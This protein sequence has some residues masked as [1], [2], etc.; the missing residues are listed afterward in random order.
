M[1]NASAHR[2]F[3]NREDDELTFPRID[4]FR[5]FV[6]EWMKK[7]PPGYRDYDRWCKSWQAMDRGRSAVTSRLHEISNALR[8][9]RGIVN[10]N[11]LRPYASADYSRVPVVQIRDSKIPQLSLAKLFPKAH[12]IRVI[13]YTREHP[14]AHIHLELL[15]SNEVVR[16]GWPSLD[17]LHGEPT[18]ST[19]QMA[20][21]K[22]YVA[23]HGGDIGE[24][25]QK[26]FHQSNLARAV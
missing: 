9:P 13:V 18:L 23:L 8:H 11:V 5:G 19:H 4:H 24:K 16:L 17:P 14:P 25:V 7:Q 21:L 2:N 12:G 10:S 26:V 6:S 15:D 3:H 20:N 22:S 1:A